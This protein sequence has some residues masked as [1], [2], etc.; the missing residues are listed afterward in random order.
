MLLSFGIILAGGIVFTCVDMFVD[1]I[2][3][4]YFK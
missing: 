2:Q 1:W 4:K 3:E